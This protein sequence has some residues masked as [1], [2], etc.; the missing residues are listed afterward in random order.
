[1]FAK[2]VKLA[3]IVVGLLVAQDAHSAVFS[4]P[5]GDV[6]A[7]KNAINT[8]NN[9][10]E[11]DIIELASNGMYILS[12]VEGSTG[13][14]LP[15]ITSDAGKSLTI[16]GNGATIMRSTVPAT[17]RFRISSAVRE[18]MLRLSV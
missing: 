3:G 2:S 15:I 4:I 5:D 18:P 11:D 6:A 13:N 9:N 8:S 7:L 12:T 16:H 17:P 10:G 14:G 1:M